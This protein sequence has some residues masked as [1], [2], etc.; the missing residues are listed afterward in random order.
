MEHAK[1]ERAK[2]KPGWKPSKVANDLGFGLT[3]G[4][5]KRFWLEICYLTFAGI[6]FK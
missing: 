4:R 6:F 3:F 1:A 2:V 5:I